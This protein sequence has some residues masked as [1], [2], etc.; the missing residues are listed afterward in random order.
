MRVGGRGVGG[1]NR[2]AGVEDGQG[3][4]KGHIKGEAKAIAFQTHAK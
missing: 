4:I 2:K 1:E 3:F